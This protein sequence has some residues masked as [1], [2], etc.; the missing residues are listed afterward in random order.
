M[1]LLKRCFVL[2]TDMSKKSV[3]ALVWAMGIFCFPPWVNP[4]WAQDYPNKPIRLI[5]P[6]TPGVPSDTIARILAPQM[7]KFIGQTIVVENKPGA[8]Q[9]IGYEYVAKDAAADGYT[10]AVTSP[11]AL[12]TL[13]LSVKD[14]RFNPVGD[15]LPIISLVEG[16]F[17]LVSASWKSF[18][19]MVTQAKANPGKFNY[20]A[21]SSLV[22]LPTEALV[23]DLGLNIVYIP[24]SGGGPY[25]SALVAGDVQMGLA[26]EGTA[27]SFKEKLRA[28]AVTGAQRSPRMADIP[29]FAELGNLGVRGFIFQLNVRV[30]TPRTAIDRLY[31]ATS[32]ALQQPEVK[33]SASRV[34][35]DI[36]NDTQESA[37]RRL[38]VEGAFFSDI[39]KKMGIR[40]E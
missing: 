40:P 10:V 28:L 9:L 23:R 38:Q 33:L 2:E 8:G 11:S 7:A 22:R 39:A 24:Y 5:V 20:G 35:F 31:G 3:L 26:D 18:S 14:L 30:G 16:K 36:V 21:S 12:A 32:Q 29:T 25:Y 19:E 4:G 15:L 27:I 1:G 34:L 6:N 13:P 17:V 37:L